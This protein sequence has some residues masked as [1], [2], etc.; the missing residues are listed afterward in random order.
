M[1]A[2]WKDTCVVS[3][4]ASFL[5]IS[6]PVLR[7]Q[8]G[9]PSHYVCASDPGSLRQ[10]VFLN[11]A[12][13]TPEE[14]EVPLL[15][16]MVFLFQVVH[17]A[18]GDGFPGSTTQRSCL[19]CLYSPLESLFHLHSAS[20]LFQISQMQSGFGQTTVPQTLVVVP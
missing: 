20:T 11:E 3:S 14:V 1:E 18:T 2:K 13:L 8:R 6:P 10:S 17:C 4:R 5:P 12:K 9:I 19:T 7:R 16:S 15:K